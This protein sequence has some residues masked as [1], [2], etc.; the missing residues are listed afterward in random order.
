[1][2]EPTD[3]EELYNEQQRKALNKKAKKHQLKVIDMLW[4]FEDV[5]QINAQSLKG[6]V[7][8]I[9]KIEIILK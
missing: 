6:N 1:M 2:A 8:S 7:A 5:L 4:S 3:F 9:K